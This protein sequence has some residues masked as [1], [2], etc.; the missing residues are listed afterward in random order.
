MTSAF[1]KTMIGFISVFLISTFSFSPVFAVTLVDEDW[2]SGRIDTAKWNFAGLTEVVDL[3]DG[4]FA[5]SITDTDIHHWESTIMSREAFARGGKLRVTYKIWGEGLE[6]AEGMSG[7]VPKHGSCLYGPW[8]FS[9][10][11]LASYFTLEAALSQSSN[12]F[13]FTENGNYRNRKMPDSDAFTRALAQADSKK[14]A[15]II[16]V[17]LGDDNGAS[18]EWKAGDQW[19]TSMDTRGTKRKDNRMSRYCVP[20]E[21]VGDNPRAKIGFVT[22]KYKAYVDDIVVE[23]DLTEEEYQSL[24]ASLPP[25][26]EHIVRPEAVPWTNQNYDDD[27]DKFQ[28]AVTTDLT[29]GYKYP[30]FEIAVEKINLL[31]PE[32]VLTVGDLVEGYV[33]NAT[34]IRNMFEEFDSWVAGFEVP[35]F[36]V[37]GNHDVGIEWKDNDLMAR[38]WRERYGKEYYHFIYKDVLFVCLNTTDNGTHYTLD[39]KQTDWARKILAENAGVRWTIVIMHDPLWEYKWDTGWPTVEDALIGRPHT[40]FAGHYHRFT[41]F[42]RNDQNY[43][44]LSGTGG[45]FQEN[46]PVEEKGGMDHF[47]WVTMTDDGPIVANITLPGVYDD[48]VM[49]EEKLRDYLDEWS[50][51]MEQRARTHGVYKALEEPVDEEMVTE[52]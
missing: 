26:P 11:E 14:N 45:S 16:R 9:F 50:N 34:V 12:Y 23:N 35:F 44:V 28:F 4:D 21:H 52:P 6:M 29:G 36:Y 43:Y 25:E 5:L 49:T 41:K 1:Q 42:K 3:E 33:N 10:Y 38:M 20:R 37:P 40:V 48:E 46:I 27:P 22:V 30:V 15:V 19:H 2:D 32:F 17:T 24:E 51:W 18:F 7:L 39:T 31:R 8:H 13:C 47:A